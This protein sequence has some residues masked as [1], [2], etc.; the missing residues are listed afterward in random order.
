M[1]KEVAEWYKLEKKP[2]QTCKY[3]HSICKQNKGPKMN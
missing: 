3:K 1:R 2:I